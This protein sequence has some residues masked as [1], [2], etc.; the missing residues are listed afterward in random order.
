MIQFKQLQRSL[1]NSCAQCHAYGKTT[2]RFALKWP[3]NSD[4]DTYANFVIMNKF[5]DQ[6]WRSRLHDDRS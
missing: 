5:S 2:S 1:L 4:G 3:A 6:D